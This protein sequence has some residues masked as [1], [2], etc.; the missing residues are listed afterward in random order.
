MPILRRQH[1]LLHSDTGS[2]KTLAYL[3]PLLCQL[4]PTRPGQLVVIV[5]SRELA[6]QTAAVVERFWPHAGTR[7]AFVLLPTQEPVS[8]DWQRV[9][10]AACPVLVAT[11]K[12][13]LRLFKHLGGTDRLHSRNQIRSGGAALTKFASHVQTV[14]LDEADALLVSKEL[15]QNGPPPKGGEQSG[16]NAELF[17]QPAAPTKKKVT[18]VCQ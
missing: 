14:V 9:T 10:A 6:V 15:A 3:L 5:P 1:T 7:R 4:H 17:S 16:R 18:A 13:L 11:P 8:D 12:P 2:G